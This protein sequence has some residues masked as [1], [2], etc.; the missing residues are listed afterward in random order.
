MRGAK[1]LPVQ[2]C[3]VQYFIRSHLFRA[4]RYSIDGPEIRNSVKLYINLVV[5]TVYHVMPGWLLISSKLGD[6]DNGRSTKL[7]FHC[8][9]STES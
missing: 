1:L 6:N 3:F 7:P 8:D 9:R 4:Y 2:L 5:K